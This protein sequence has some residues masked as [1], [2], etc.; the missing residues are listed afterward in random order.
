MPSDV[1]VFPLEPLDGRYT[2]QWY[3]E[4]PFLLEE[5]LLDTDYHVWNAIGQQ[6][7]D[8]TTPGAFLDFADTNFWKSTQ[9][10]DFVNALSEPRGVKDDASLL[11]TD[12]WNPALL[13]VAY[14]RDLLNKKWKIHAIAHAGAYDP[15]DI[16]GI[17]M[18]KPW[19]W[20]LERSLFYACDRLYFATHFHRDMFLANLSIP[21]ED[22]YRAVVSGQPHD[23]I[24]R[25]IAGI[26]LEYDRKIQ[27]IWPHRYS[28]DKQ[29]EI[30]ESLNFDF[31]VLITQKLKLNKETYYQTLA[32]S[33]MIFSCALHENLGISVMEGVLLGAMP[34][35]PDRCSYSE[36]YLPEFKYPSEWT[37]SLENFNTSRTLLIGRISDM[38]RHPYNY[39]NALAKQQKILIDN[40]M[41]ADVM[42]D[43][44]LTDI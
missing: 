16:L 17:K 32:N 44:I 2:K 19:P 40:Y 20:H 31:N 7:S 22:H 11:F 24:L 10:A 8:N 12:F 4:I 6:R 27:I 33:Q 25:H 41:T 1:W 29:P 26:K 30:A 18:A 43:H 3:T 42:L 39:N 15:S 28:E 35:V 34:L 37:T 13:Q 38:L 23:A 36:M 21:A 5:R 9:L 14:M